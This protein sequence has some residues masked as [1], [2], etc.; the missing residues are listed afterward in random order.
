MER[1]VHQCRSFEEADAID[2]ADWLTLSGDE[3]LRIGE[4]LRMSAFE[5]GNEKMERVIAFRPMADTEHESGF[6]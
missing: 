4:E 3:R 5:H 2:F 6:S 1:V